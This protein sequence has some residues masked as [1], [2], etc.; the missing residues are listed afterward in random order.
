MDAIDLST[1]S[2]AMTKFGQRTLGIDSMEVAV[3]AGLLMAVFLLAVGTIWRGR[4]RAESTRAQAASTGGF[5]RWLTP[6]GMQSIPAEQA[7]VV[8]PRRK[9]G[10]MK[11]IKVS[12]P[13][14]K[15]PV[16]ALKKAGA[17]ALDIARKTG[18]ARDAVVMMMANANPQMADMKQKKAENAT[19]SAP[20]R[21]VNTERAMTAP[22]AYGNAPR[23]QPAVS[24]SRG[25]VGTR[26]S[27]RVS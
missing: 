5:K 22:G 1:I 18:L 17:D 26:F 20:T 3:A 11:A 12:T 27:A 21:T 2:A 6:M 10:S 25:T 15:V 13:V 9:S 14:S 7:V 24:G 19:K 23:T 8:R 4:R 16:R